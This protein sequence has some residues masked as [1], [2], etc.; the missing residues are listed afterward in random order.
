MLTPVNYVLS[1]YSLQSSKQF[2]LLVCIASTCHLAYELSAS[3]VAAQA[4]EFQQCGTNFANK[5][6]GAIHVDIISIS[7]P[8]HMTNI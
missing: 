3:L 6:H 7:V 2:I 1:W 8:N 5:V 4:A